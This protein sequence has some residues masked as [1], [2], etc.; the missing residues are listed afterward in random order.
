MCNQIVYIDDGVPYLNVQ[1][2]KP[3]LIEYENAKK[4]DPI[5]SK[6]ILHKSLCKE[7]QVLLTIA[8]TL[9]N[10]AVVHNLPYLTNSN[11]AIAN[12]ELNEDFS[13]YFISTYINSRYGQL[14]IDR[15]T[16][17]SVQPNLLLTQVKKLKIPILSNPFQTAIANLVQRAFELQQSSQKLYKEAETLLLE[18]LGLFQQKELK[19]VHKKLIENCLKN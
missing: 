3:N 17:S 8:G 2:I 13:P 14:E 9:G 1:D 12:I 4:I 15:L 19:K 5:I 11:Q 10:A 16:I 6:D 7:G 18:E